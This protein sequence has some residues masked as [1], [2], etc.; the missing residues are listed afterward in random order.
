MDLDAL[1]ITMR[2]MNLT[3]SLSYIPLLVCISRAIY[4]RKFDA[5]RRIED[6][7]GIP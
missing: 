2:S 6:Q 5:L 7:L 1:I 3:V 4:S